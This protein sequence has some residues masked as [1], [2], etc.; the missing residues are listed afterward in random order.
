MK[1][2]RLAF[3]LIFLAL[4]TQADAQAQCRPGAVVACTTILGKPGTRTCLGE[5]EGFGPCEATASPPV[6]G[7]VFGKYLILTVIY[8]PPGTTAPQ[9]TT[10]EQSFS[11]VSYESDSST[12][13]TKTISSSFKQD[14]QVSFKSECPDVC[15]LSGGASFEYTH[16]TT[17]SDAVNINKKTSST[18]ID[19]GP[20]ED[21]IDHNFDQIWLFLHPKFDV[22]ILGTEIIWALDPIS[23]RVLSSMFMLAG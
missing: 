10:G 23:R 3:P 8:A 7:I 13:S 12:G 18:I 22:T 21:A 6:S 2:A 20:V 19:P 11:Q 14:Y 15:F 5:G 17:H 16:N 9:T 1:F 4:T